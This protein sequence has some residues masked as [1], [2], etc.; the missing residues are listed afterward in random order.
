MCPAVILAASRNDRVI[1]RTKTLVVSIR[2]K[3][4]FSHSGAPSG[5]KW[6]VDFLGANMKPEINM[7][8]HIGSPIVRVIIRCLE[9]DGQ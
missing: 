2:T 1:G 9:D 7:L 6:A 8:I 4:G 3:K 5:R